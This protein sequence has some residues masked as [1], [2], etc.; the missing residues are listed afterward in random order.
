MLN[1]NPIYRKIRIF[2]NRYNYYVKEAENASRNGDKE[3]A[4]A[5]YAQADNCIIEIDKLLEKLN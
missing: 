5:L 4:K 3:G 2:E 1:F